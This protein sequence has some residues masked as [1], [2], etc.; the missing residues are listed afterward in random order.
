MTDAHNTYGNAA[1]SGH[2]VVTVE[3]KDEPEDIVYVA[4][5]PLNAEDAR[6]HMDQMH[7]ALMTIHLR[8]AVRRRAIAKQ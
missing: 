6:A 5:R 8:K 2:A 3:V 1:G 7:N 4:G